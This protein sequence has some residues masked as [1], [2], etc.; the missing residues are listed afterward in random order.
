MK[1]FFKYISYI[2]ADHDGKPSIKHILAIIFSFDLLR[3]FDRAG[4]AI[5]KMLRILEEGKTIDPVVIASLGSL[6]ANDAII[7]GAEAALIAGLLSLTT[8]QSL[9]LNRPSGDNP[10][11]AFGDNSPD[12]GN[13]PPHA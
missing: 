5:S 6:L 1:K 4:S 11:P 8:Y 9:Q 7:I 2:W 13:I 3:N 12:P 10:G